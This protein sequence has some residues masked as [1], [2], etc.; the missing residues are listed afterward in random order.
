M[1]GDTTRCSMDK[2]WNLQRDDFL[3]YVSMGYRMSIQKWV[4]YNPY[5]LLYGREPFFPSCIQYLEDDV[6]DPQNGGSQIIKLQLA[7]RGAMLQKVMSLAVR[8]LVTLRVVGLRDRGVAVLQ[9]KDG[10]TISHQVAKLAQ[11][12]VP[13]P[14]PQIYPET[15][16]AMHS[17]MCGS[18]FD[19]V[20][21]LLSDFC[22]EGFY[23]PW[24]T[25]T[26]SQCWQLEMWDSQGEL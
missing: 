1:L 11:C 22:N 13:L 21:M 18:K 12:W 7:Y 26:R 5:F 17:H 8:N 24:S 19:P 6:I 9:N 25:C 14:D 20:V 3:L 10:A 15:Y 2:K 23:L 4:G 16:D